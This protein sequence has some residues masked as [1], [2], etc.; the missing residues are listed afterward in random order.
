M[1]KKSIFTYCKGLR[2]FFKA[3]NSITES[4][5]KNVKENENLD[6]LMRNDEL[7]KA[8]QVKCHCQEN[9]RYI[10]KTDIGKFQFKIAIYDYI[11]YQ[12]NSWIRF[13]Q[14][15][16][17]KQNEN[18]L[19]IEKVPYEQELENMFNGYSSYKQHKNS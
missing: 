9:N 19:E 14:I 16:K 3:M 8:W 1:K 15:D 6:T 18:Y 5:L 12:T 10:F 7:M 13:V 2:E 4:K 17:Y 11:I